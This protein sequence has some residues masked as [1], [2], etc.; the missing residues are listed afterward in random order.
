MRPDLSELFGQQNLLQWAVHF[1]RSVRLDGSADQSQRVELEK[2]FLL[3]GDQPLCA[4][5]LARIK[6]IQPATPSGPEAWRNFVN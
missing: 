6:K 4:S 2:K 5:K 3:S 1:V